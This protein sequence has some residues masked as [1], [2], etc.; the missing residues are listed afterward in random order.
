MSTI[1]SFKNVENKQDLPRGI[2]CIKRFY[3]S[4]REHAMQII[5]FKTEQKTI[6]NKESYEN[7]NICYICWEKVEDR[8]AR[9]KIYCKV[10][11]TCHYTG[12]Y[13]GAAHSICNW[14]IGS[15]S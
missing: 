2:E 14:K 4:L 3:E 1:S 10:I 11:D 12:E 7:A 15:F 13:R 6:N 9:D 8:Q 5:N